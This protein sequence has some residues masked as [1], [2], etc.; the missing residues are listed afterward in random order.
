MGRLVA[1]G[2]SLT[3]GH[4]LPDCF[5]PPIHPGDKPSE[6]SWPFLL[7]K[8][9]GL[10]V[11]NLGSPGSGNLEIL[12]K[13]LQYNFDKNDLCI[14]HW[15]FYERL[16]L[17]RLSTDHTY[18]IN[19]ENIDKEF[20]SEQ[21]YIIHTELRNFMVIHHAYLNLEKINIPYLFIDKKNHVVPVPSFL[22]TNNY[23][24]YNL[25]EYFTLDLALDNS[26]PGIESHKRFSDYLYRKITHLKII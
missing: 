22:K 25:N 13:L 5:V 24:N 6:Y 20:L 10:E 14:V 9:L 16:D 4:G 8:K 1:F 15:S 12:Y 26:H 21:G 11:V 7:G 19:F 17:V 3:Y 18:R 2:C 23:S